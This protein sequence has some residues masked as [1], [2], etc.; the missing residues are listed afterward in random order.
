M[1]NSNVDR[2][3]I[4]YKGFIKAD[5]IRAQQIRERKECTELSSMDEGA[6]IKKSLTALLSSSSASIVGAVAILMLTSTVAYLVGESRSASNTDDTTAIKT[7]MTAGSL[8]Q[9][10]T[11]E[12]DAVSI[13][14]D[15]I[16]IEKRKLTQK[17][18]E[19]KVTRQDVMEQ[20]VAQ[21]D[22][23]QVTR[24]SLLRLKQSLAP[25]SSDKQFNIDRGELD[26]YALSLSD[27]LSGYVVNQVN[28]ELENLRLRVISMIDNQSEAGFEE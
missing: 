1:M 27:P 9:Q 6:T 26:D 18:V 12:V 13:L 15:K 23:A 2:Y 24:K 17:T 19:P 8:A 3:G 10:P 11:V 20:E 4:P 22:M 25:Q 5:K 14:K 7:E 28:P 16:E 21:Q